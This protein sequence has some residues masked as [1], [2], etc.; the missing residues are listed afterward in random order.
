MSRIMVDLF[1][2]DIRPSDLVIQ[3]SYQ[4]KA[5]YDLPYG[6]WTGGIPDS[7]FVDSK[8]LFPYLVHELF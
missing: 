6:K 4:V 8:F 5:I 1:I 7:L 2:D 3:K